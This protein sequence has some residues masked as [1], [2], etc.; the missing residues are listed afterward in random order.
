MSHILRSF[1]SLPLGIED[2]FGFFSDA[3]N[4]ERITPPELRFHI[5]TPQPIV[6]TKGTHID[7]RLRLCGVPFRWQTRITH[8]EPPLQFVDEQIRGPYKQW[9]HTHRFAEEH[10]TTTIED[11]VQYQLPLWPLGEVA[12]PLVHA[13]LQRLFR[14]RQ[15][16]IRLALLG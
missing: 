6:I 15:Q 7:Y 1:M 2:V 4:L 11:E 12:Y 14:F 16:A 3:S 5:L 9:I 10:G 13:Q 8:W